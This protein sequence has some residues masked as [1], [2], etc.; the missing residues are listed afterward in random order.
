MGTNYYH[1]TDI[2]DCCNRYK[3]QH[4]GKSSGGWEFFFQGYNAEEH[5]PA[6]ISFEDWKREIQAE[7]KIYDE[8]GRVYTLDEF[9]EFVESKQGG[10]FNNRPNINHYD[11]CKKQEL[12]DMKNDWKDK[13]GYSFSSTEFS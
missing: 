10:T 6:I 9:V 4:I 11:Y 5:R 12:C 2:C 3:E 7:G 1:R 8:Y 13:E